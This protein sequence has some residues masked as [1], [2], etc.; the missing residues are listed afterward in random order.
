M[1][2][3]EA[4]TLPLVGTHVFFTFLVL[5]QTNTNSVE[6]QLPGACGFKAAIN[7]KPGNAHLLAAWPP[8]GGP[9]PSN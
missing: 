9:W 7:P 2:R 1:P 8:S 3:G 4:S 6:R 5:L